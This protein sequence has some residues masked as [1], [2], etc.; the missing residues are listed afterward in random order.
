MTEQRR[1]QPTIKWKV[2]RG[3]DNPV[4]VIDKDTKKIV[5]R[6]YDFSGQGI[7]QVKGDPSSR[8]HNILLQRQRKINA[9]KR[10]GMIILA[11]KLMEMNP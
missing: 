5:L 6:V 9:L 8:N 1:N 11:V 7:N 2:V 10:A 4:E 3:T